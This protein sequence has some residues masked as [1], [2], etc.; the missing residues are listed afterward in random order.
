MNEHL[1]IGDRERT[2]AA[3]RLAAHAAAGRLSFDEL[4]QR[5]D[6]VQ[7]AVL[8]RDLHA[9]EGDLPTPVR[10]ASPPRS[11]ADLALAVA[12]LAAAVLV[13]ILVGH[14]IPPL[15]IAAFLLWRARG[16]RRVVGPPPAAARR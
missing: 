12:M 16:G 3:E 10:R 13:T 8:V 11:T 6:A 1:R 7:S 5:L 2:E 4:E 14:P 15:F 9:I